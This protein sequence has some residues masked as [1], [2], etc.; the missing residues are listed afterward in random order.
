MSA[1][2]NGQDPAP[3]DRTLSA[4]SVP[5]PMEDADRLDRAPWLVALGGLVAGVAA[6]GIGEATY[7]VI[8]AKLVEVPTSGTVVMAATAQT[9]SVA[10]V[11]NAALAYAALG[12]CLGGCLGLAGGLARRSWTAAAAAGLLGLLLGAG[13]PAGV[14]LVTLKAFSEARVHVPDYDIALSM[15]MHGLIWGL[16]GGASGLAF[17][18]GTGGRGRLAP[19]ALMGLLGAVLGAVAFD[20]VGAAFFMQAD[21]GDPISTTWP[22]RLMARLMVALLTA[23]GVILSL[24]RAMPDRRGGGATSASESEPRRSS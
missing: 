12:G 18:V 16:I 15:A 4:S 10:D 7:K 2:V 24:P 23:A 22:S 21:T 20:L 8:V 9:Q 3:E 6:F 14:S 1:S 5:A 17:A 13:L 19:A 11:W